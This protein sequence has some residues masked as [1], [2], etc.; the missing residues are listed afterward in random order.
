MRAS[1]SRRVLVGQPLQER[2]GRVPGTTDLVADGIE[3]PGQA[4]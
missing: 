4:L 2:D 1:S 3:G